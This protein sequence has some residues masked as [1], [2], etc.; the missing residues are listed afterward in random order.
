M[1][2]GQVPLHRTAKP[3]NPKTVVAAMKDHEE[4]APIDDL[5]ATLDSDPLASNDPDR[6]TGTE[7][8]I[9]SDAPATATWNAEGASLP[10]AIFEQTSAVEQTLEPAEQSLIRQ[11]CIAFAKA[12]EDGKRPPELKKFLLEDKENCRFRSRLAE[13][14][15]TLDLEFRV[16]FDV[17]LSENQYVSQLPEFREVIEQ[18]YR[19]SAAHV[20]RTRVAEGAESGG[21]GLIRR[22]SE[23]P[24]ARYHPTKLHARGGLG[25]VYHAR[26]QELNR[27]VALK[28]ILPEHSDK[29]HFQEKFLFEAEITGS[30]EH[31][32]IVP[33]YGLGRYSDDQPYYAMR[34]I[35]GQTFGDRIRVFHEANRPP[36]PSSYFD[37]E[38]RALLRRLIDTCNAMHFAHEHG[39]LHRDLKP[40]NVMLGNYGETLVVD[41]GLAKQL[42]DRR[43]D[44][45]L[46]HDKTLPGS[47]GRDDSSKTRQGAIVGTPMYM[48]PEQAMG[49]IDDLDG[50]TDI[51]SLGAM[52]F[53]IVTGE[54]PIAG[55]T[56]VDVIQNV[57]VGKVRNVH[58]L[59]PKAPRALASICRKAMALD[60]NDRYAN[61]IEFAEDIERWINDELVLAHA[62]DES[63][64]ERSGRL[65][66]RYR[67]WTLSGAASMAVITLVSLFAAVLVNQA[68][69]QERIA[70]VQASEFKQDAVNRYRRSREAIDTW[71]VQS[72]D[73]LQFFPGTQAIRERLLQRAV[74]DY[75]QLSDDVSDDPQ[76]E[77][78]RGRAL[79]RIGDLMQMQN[80]EQSA[81][82]YFAK[83]TDVFQ[84]G[85]DDP[86][87]DVDFRSEAANVLVRQGISASTEARVADA[88][89][90]FQSAIAMLGQL[91]SKSDNPLPRKVLASSH[92]NLGKLLVSSDPQRAIDQLLV[93]LKQYQAVDDLNDLSIGLAVAHTHDLLGQVYRDFGDYDAA[94]ASLIEGQDLLESLVRDQPDQPEYLNALASLFVS[95]A[96]A[97]REQG[98]DGESTRALLGA[99][100]HYRTLRAALPGV[101]R[102]AENLA[103]ALTDLSLMLHES[104]LN[105]QAAE[106]SEEADQI[107]SQLV[108]TYGEAPRI[109]EAYASCKD[110]RGQIL[111]DLSEKPG[112]SALVAVN[113]L[114]DLTQAAST[115]D[116]IKRLFERLAI[117]QSHFGR[118]ARVQG[119]FDLAKRQFQESIQRL[120]SLVEVQGKIP[121]LVNALAEVHRR[122][123]GVLHVTDDPQ[124]E[125][126]FRA[127]RDLWTNLG[128][129]R[130]AEHYDQLSWMLATCPEVEMVD[131]D[132]AVEFAGQAVSRSAFNPD[133]L[134]SQALAA[135][136]NGRARS[137]LE[138]IERAEALR[139]DA[140]DRDYYVRAIVFSLQGEHT[141]ARKAFEQ[142]DAWREQQR[143]HSPELNRLREIT[144]KHLGSSD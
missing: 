22:R 118:Q 131:L 69:K 102:Y 41:W 90:R 53:Y 18:A 124:S 26:D 138:L 67:S 7:T 101:P 75:E 97:F 113:V 80:D 5:E 71:L 135:S 39:V 27:L 126:H 52:L 73:A 72:S 59:V 55:K 6:T 15:V 37:R 96:S 68:R 112:D 76:L 30:L 121:R 116:Q 49:R 92:H 91:V 136:L 20:E 61:A 50:R 57:R 130:T 93:S 24:D 25:A 11:R 63:V 134:T 82:E 141:Q 19:R 128:D 127:A 43:D 114:L 66:R 86:E 111:T 109:L 125:S 28:E 85:F 77:L 115:D 84:R 123:A 31:P 62:N 140:I 137:A 51:Y 108:R 14:L 105:V 33:V 103:V 60:A 12:W 106:V 46:P 74:R 10:G 17:S 16:T 104:G 56:S 99:V 132:A 29:P 117:A 98:R 81:G 54:R 129:A 21:M 110:A 78:E 35:R 8:Y 95:K 94:F 2:T 79:V 133:Y 9:K 48:S 144:Q 3:L 139:G 122:Y 143:P 40:D 100:E 34:F 64:W 44:S 58:D 45:P 120:N 65:I 70:K 47:R 13:E 1:K 4:S 142:A 87:L 38:F 32:G 83:A 23:D 107:L 89:R 119:K 42:S 88:E 36:G